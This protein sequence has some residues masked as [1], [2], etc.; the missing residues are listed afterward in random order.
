MLVGYIRYVV[1]N[2]EGVPITWGRKRRLFEGPA[3]DAVRSMAT[4]CTHPGCRVRLKRTQ[5]DHTVDFARGGHTDPGNGNP[6]CLRHNLTKN[7]GFT[8]WRDPTGDW[9]TYRPDGTEVA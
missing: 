7:R 4:R 1:R 8:V 2:E 6:R 5:T 3:R 9:H